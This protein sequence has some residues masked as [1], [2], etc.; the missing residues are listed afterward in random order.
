MAKGAD[1]AV[2]EARLGHVFRDRKLL[3]EALTHVSRG[4]GGPTYQRLEFLGDRVLG[5]AIA[6]LLMRTFPTG[7]E[8]DLSRRL[9]ELVRKETC[10]AVA[11]DWDLGPHLRLGGGGT[12]AMRRNLSILGDACESVIGAVF[13][14]AGFE[15]AQAVVE[16]AFE[17]R[18]AALVKVPANPKTQL[19][20]WAATRGLAPPVYSIV[21]RE[22]PDHAPI[23][24][25]VARLEGFAEAIGTGN[26]RRAAEQ[27]AAQALLVR[28]RVVKAPA[29]EKA[30]V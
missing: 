29:R 26:S 16:R 2:L 7:T 17:P 8:G 19:Q 6:D 13:M 15:V 23:F 11:A 4:A 22:G 9:S 24:R 27:E 12:G 1:P 21:E 18:L 5:L 28:E 10:A 30:D 3:A 20:E 14:D 25:V